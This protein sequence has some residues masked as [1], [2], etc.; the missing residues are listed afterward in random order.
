MVMLDVHTLAED[1]NQCGSDADYVPG[2][3]FPLEIQ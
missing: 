3:S 1:G 2:R